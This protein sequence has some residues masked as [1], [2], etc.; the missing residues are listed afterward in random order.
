MDQV[1]I[2]QKE[3]ASLKE[4]NKKVEAN[5]A[6]ETSYTRRIWVAVTTYLI[7]LIFFLVIKVENPYISAIVP[8]I[9][10]I[11]STLSL[12]FLKKIWIGNFYK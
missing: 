10:F 7:I 3:I 6:W 8:T 2:L 1:E 11:L 12:N 4:R 9:W 5:K